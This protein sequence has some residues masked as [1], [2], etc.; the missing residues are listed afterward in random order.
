MAERRS[1]LTLVGLILA[2][3]AGVALLGIPAFAFVWMRAS[4][5]KI[6]GVAPGKFCTSI[7]GGTRSASRS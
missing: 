7:E 3:L 5:L 4:R 1:H 6:D 2:A